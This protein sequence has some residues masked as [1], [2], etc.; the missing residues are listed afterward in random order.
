[1]EVGDWLD[2]DLYNGR[3]VLV[4]N[5]FVFK[6]PVF[7]YSGEFSFLWV[8]FTVPVRFGS[9][10]TVAQGLI[11]TAVAEHLQ[12][13]FDEA[14]REWKRMVKKFLIERARIGPLVTLAVTDNWI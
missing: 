2:G 9:D 13:F 4:A 6:E 7:N 11:E 10:W 14:S 3:V 5:S 8:E 12:P 1:M